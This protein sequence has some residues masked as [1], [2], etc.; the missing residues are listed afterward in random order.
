MAFQSMTSALGISSRRERNVLN[1]C[2]HFSRIYLSDE[3]KT[4]YIC[5][6]PLELQTGA[7]TL[8]QEEIEIFGLIL[9]QHSPRFL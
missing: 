3:D 7:H 8:F 4:I 9:H 2:C 6:S 1:N 5:G